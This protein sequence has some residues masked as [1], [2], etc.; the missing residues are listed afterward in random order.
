[1]T[2][3]FIL[4]VCSLQNVCKL[5]LNQ[6]LELYDVN[7]NTCRSQINTSN[8]PICQIKRSEICGRNRIS[9][10]PQNLCRITL[11]RIILYFSGKMFVIN[12]PP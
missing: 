7:I 12:A 9:V 8:H 3:F 11:F 5:L 4:K 1:M 2:I 10:V 6:S